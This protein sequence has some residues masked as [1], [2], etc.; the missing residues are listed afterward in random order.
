MQIIQ[1]M[2]WD[3]QHEKARFYYDVKREICLQAVRYSGY[4]PRVKA[5]ECLTKQ[6]CTLVHCHYHTCMLIR[7]EII[8]LPVSISFSFILYV[9][10]VQDDGSTGIV[11]E[12]D[13]EET[14]LRHRQHWGYPNWW[15]QQLCFCDIIDINRN[16]ICN[17]NLIFVWTFVTSIRRRKN[18]S[19]WIQW[20]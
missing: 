8:F 19:L 13:G 7:G 10:Q 14:A 9:D 12:H 4:S 5:Q 2:R 17:Q 18:N 20:Y 15:A 6:P 3:N 16:A 1:C 11:E